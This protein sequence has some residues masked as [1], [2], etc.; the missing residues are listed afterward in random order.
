MKDKPVIAESEEILPDI[1]ASDA[2]AFRQEYRSTNSNEITIATL[3]INSLPRKFSSLKEIIDSKIDVLIV[4]E[5][6]IDATFP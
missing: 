2:L 3:D 4:Q 5:T 6:K 1:E